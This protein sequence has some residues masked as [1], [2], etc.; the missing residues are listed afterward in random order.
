MNGKA[1]ARFMRSGMRMGKVFGRL[2]QFLW[3]ESKKL[4]LLGMCPYKAPYKNLRALRRVG[5]IQNAI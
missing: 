4:K 5:Y 3:Q 1:H 2:G